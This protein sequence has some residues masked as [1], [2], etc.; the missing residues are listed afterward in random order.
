MWLELSLTLVLG[1]T[2]ASSAIAALFV[3]SLFGVT[4]FALFGD[5]DFLDPI[6]DATIEDVYAFLDKLGKS[7]N[8]YL[9]AANAALLLISF[10]LSRKFLS[11]ERGER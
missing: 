8:Y 3:G 1:E 4:A 10:P 2:A 9:T 5:I 11:L 6:L 7:I